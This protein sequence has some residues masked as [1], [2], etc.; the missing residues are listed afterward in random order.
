MP[1]AAP[2]NAALDA[3][4]WATLPLTLVQT[5]PLAALLA[6]PGS[7]GDLPPVE[8][9]DAPCDAWLDMVAQHKGTLPA[10]AL[11]VLTR[12]PEV[13]FAQVHDAAGGLLAVARGAVTDP[14][15]WHGITLVQVSPEARRRGL[16]RHL[17]RALADWA[18]RRGATRAYLQ[19]EQRNTA[20]TGLYGSLGFHTHHTYLTRRSPVAPEAA[21]S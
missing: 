3:R 17:V 8:F 19:V 1:L 2:V 5:A 20:A 13:V 6:G 9:A 14:D 16:A 11:H 21:G 10:A 7:A 15:R 4:G 18:A 12:V